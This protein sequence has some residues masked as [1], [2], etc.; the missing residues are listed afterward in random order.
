VDVFVRG[1]NFRCLCA[2]LEQETVPQLQ[3]LQVQELL[4]GPA[5]TKLPVIL[6]GDFNTDSLGRDGSFAYNLMPAAGFDDAWAALNPTVPTAGLTWGHDEFLADPTLAFDS[7]I[8][9]VFYRGKGIV[10]MQAGVLD[11]ETGL[12]Q[13]PLWASDHAAFGVRFLLK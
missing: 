5:K 7:R 4:A 2:H 10:P 11:M 13:P 9:F 6:F 1:M 12:S 8:D 3:A